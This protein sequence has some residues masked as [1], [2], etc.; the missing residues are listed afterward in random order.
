MIALDKGDIR[1]KLPATEYHVSRKVDG[2]FAVLVFEAGEALL[3]NPGGTVR[4]GAHHAF[5]GLG[6]E[7]MPPL[8]E[9]SFLY[10]PSLLPAGSLTQALEVI[11]RQNARIRNWC[12]GTARM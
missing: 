10:M 3:V 9:G 4:V 2:E 6:R 12:A 7:F 11:G 8:D 5:P 1:Q